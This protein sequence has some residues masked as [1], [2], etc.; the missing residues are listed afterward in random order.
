MALGG[1][2]NLFDDFPTRPEG[3][4][5]EK[6]SQLRAAYERAEARLGLR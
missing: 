1:G 2:P 5:P 4:S 3:V 6:Y